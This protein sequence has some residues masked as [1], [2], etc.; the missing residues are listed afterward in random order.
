LKRF[1]EFVFSNDIYKTRYGTR[2]DRDNGFQ[3]GGRGGRNDETCPSNRIKYDA[4]G[5]TLPARY[6]Q[7]RDIYA[8]RYR[9]FRAKNV[10]RRAAVVDGMK[11]FIDGTGKTVLFERT[12]NV[13]GITPWISIRT[14]VCIYTYK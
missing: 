4:G 1:G 5:E 8:F 14:C 13:R 10:R 7:T 12:I 6:Y 3:N 2:R 9:V 11:G